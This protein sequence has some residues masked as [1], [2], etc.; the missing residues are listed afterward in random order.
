MFSKSTRAA[1]SGMIRLARE[2]HKSDCKPLTSKEIAT[3]TSL[4]APFIAKLLTTLSQIDLVKGNP[5]PHG[6]YILI[7]NPADI[8]LIEI[9]N[10]FEKVDPPTLCLFTPGECDHTK[11]CTMHGKLAALYNHRRSFLEDTTLADFLD[12]DPAI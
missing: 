3:D 9:A 12:Y 11:Q 1:I 10:C 4:Q 6:G 7:S 2:Y 8:K 5:G